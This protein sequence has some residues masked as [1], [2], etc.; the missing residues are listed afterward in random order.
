MKKLISLFSL[1][2]MAIAAHAVSQ[3]KLTLNVS[4]TTG[5]S[6][7]GLK[8]QLS[9]ELY[10]IEY[11]DATLSTEGTARFTGV[12]EG[13]N[14]LT[15]DAT[16]LGLE[17]YVDDNLT[18]SSDTTIAIVLHENTRT[19][20]NL[21]ATLQHNALTGQNNVA[22]GWNQETDYFFDDF[23][24][25][26]AFS[27]DFA[28]WTGY[29]GDKEATAVLAGTY[30]NAGLPQYATIFN[31][32]TLG[33]TYWYEYPV[34]R[35]YSGK[36]CLGIVRTASGNANNDWVITPQLT[37]GVDNVVSFMVK[38]SDTTKERYN[39]GIS[40]TG[41]N[42]SDFTMLTSGNYQT[43]G[44]EQWQEA[45]FDL[46]AYEGQQVYIAVQCV[47]SGGFMLMV[48]D[49]YVGPRSI[50]FGDDSQAKA[51]RQTLA[52]RH[53]SKANPNESFNVYQDGTL[54]GSTTD[55][56]YTVADVAA[57][58]HEYAVE[59]TYLAITT[60]KTTVSFTVPAADSYASLTINLTANTPTLPSGI[61]VE[62]TSKTTGDV[63]TTT[64][65][66]DG[67]AMIASLPKDEYLMSI[68]C[69]G[70]DTIEETVGLTEDLTLA[71]NLHETI[72]APY[73]L[74]ATQ[75]TVGN[76][77]YVNLTWNKDLGFSDSFEDYDDFAQ[78]FGDWTT[79]DGDQMPTYTMSI[80]GTTITTPEQRGLVG[81]M[82]FNP[83]KTEPVKASEDG[84]FTA[85]DGLK[86][87]MFSSAEAAQSDDWLIA[88]AQTIGQDYV[89][90]FTA[91]SY[92]Y[93]YPGTLVV[94]VMKGGDTS[95]FQALD[96]ILLTNE[97][98]RYELSLASYADGEW[99]VAVHHTSYDMWI[100]MLDDFYLGPTEEEASAAVGNCTYRVY[101]DGELEAETEESSY[102]F[103]DLSEG[104]HTLGV[105]AV[106]A[107]GQSSITEITVS[108][109]SGI[110]AI[111]A[112]EAAEQPM[113]DLSGRRII[114]TSK[115]G[116]Y[117]WQGGKKL[118]K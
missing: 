29:D 56:S 62:L 87:V 118:I 50:L 84:L 47:S 64:A 63:F 111:S 19:P 12:V 68:S 108:I 36:Q 17:K 114:G 27:I 100:S 90:R 116:L 109:A 65:D 18:I 21:Q 96:E 54:V 89:V 95:T 45:T 79:I 14:T 2:C 32:M 80:S 40:T 10:G 60:E 93:S 44:Y 33:D 106:Y 69:D 94:G 30:M 105:Q 15:I 103:A 59:A 72:V 92:S 91:K 37:I 3:Y 57:G 43:V 71:Y 7:A 4:S 113:F 1:A 24:D 75:Q 48:D 78:Q 22:L 8:A 112:A 31:L 23:E 67:K 51:R 66:A 74:Q 11:P 81:A 73:N 9:N 5:I 99:Q 85:P 76:H 104:E 53:R 26:E 16:S 49:F 35:P 70:Y 52:T 6:V 41:T 13:T 28:P 34:L 77:Q 98:T 38:G 110:D 115:Q 46:S 83:E 42:P 101:L 117:I 86:Y 25:Y 20:Y 107:T 39:V 61:K 82:I 88:P 55:Y 102:T 97:W 58:T